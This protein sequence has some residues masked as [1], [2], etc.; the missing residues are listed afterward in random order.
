LLCGRQLEK[1][2]KGSQQGV[3]D[4]RKQGHDD[5]AEDIPA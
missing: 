2:R 1:E 3:K 4:K 5:E